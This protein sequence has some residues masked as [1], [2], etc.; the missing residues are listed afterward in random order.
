MKN[1]PT[2]YPLVLSSTFIFSH[3]FAQEKL[4][5]VVVTA[6]GVETPLRQVGASV[7]VI[8]DETISLRGY[9]TVTEMLRKE[10]GISSTSA[11]G[12]GKQS[13]LSIRGE[14]GFRTLIMIDGVSMSDPTGTQVTPQ[15]Q[16]LTAGGNI[17]RIEVL[18]GPQGFI[19]GA[20]AGGV[21]NIFTKTQNDGV[22][23][24]LS[25]EVG[26]YDSSKV[27][28]FIAAGNEK[29][30]GYL[31][32][33]RVSSK[34]FNALKSDTENEDDGYANTT[35]HSKLGWNINNDARAQLILRSVSA[36]SEYDNCG[37]NDCIG[38]FDQ[39]LGRLTVDYS[40]DAVAQK[41]GLAHSNIERSL[42]AFRMKGGIEKIDYLSDF[43]INSLLN[44]VVGFDHQ[45]ETV[46][47]E[48]GEDSERNQKG[49]FGE[50]QAN[51]NDTFYF[52]FGVRRDDNDD[53]GIHQ[54]YRLTSAYVQPISTD[55]TVKLRVS[56]GTGFRAPSLS[57]I[58]FNKSEYASGDAIDTVFT[59]EQSQGLDLGV[60]YFHV[61]GANV[62]MTY[63]NQKIDDEIFYDSIGYTGYLQA[64]GTSHSKGVEISLTAPLTDAVEV[65]ANATY[66]ETEST[67]DVQRARRP[68]NSYNLGIQTVWFGEQL[69]TLLS[70]RI[71]KD[72]VNDIFG[73]G[74]VALDNYEVV[75][76][77]ASYSVTKALDFFGRVEN[78]TDEKYEEITGY[79]TA[80]AAVYVGLRYA[81]DR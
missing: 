73:V 24:A 66:N 54:S 2:I 61:S 72:S 44:A 18:R 37:G 9:S 30:D 59:E 14:D 51:V 78:L 75:D 50:L 68:K 52:T 63:F 27:D 45:T 17:E 13:S 1:F 60:D 48:G 74:R 25:A 62:S 49:I 16:H 21:V 39:D 42:G 80:G 4:E 76:F 11:G 38:E 69:K 70:V 64:A 43:S 12:L 28:G 65:V 35:A 47:P 29:G 19:Y 8:S 58:A 23:G 79:N 55:H 7:T 3:A 81:L 32:L 20:D 40:G 77:S 71:V 53:F 15:V 22:S 56:A 67:S 46:K 36:E 41:I 31:S 6:S 26:R 33:T 34:G 57:E 10:V 5:E